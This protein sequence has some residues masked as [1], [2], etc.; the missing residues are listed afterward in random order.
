MHAA[1]PPNY[2]NLI[3]VF[4]PGSGIPFP[5]LTCGLYLLV[6]YFAG[7]LTLIYLSWG[8]FSPLRWATPL[9]ALNG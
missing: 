4:K 8:P 1:F 7:F 9:T 6:H 2:M 5:C 3:G